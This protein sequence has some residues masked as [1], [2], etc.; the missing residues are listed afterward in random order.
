MK[1]AV[2]DAAEREG[3]YVVVVCVK[4]RQGKMLDPGDWDSFVPP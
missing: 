4:A 3:G 2:I 1:C